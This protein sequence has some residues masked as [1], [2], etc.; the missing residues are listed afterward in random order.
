MSLARIAYVVDGFPKVSQTFIAGEVAELLRRGI[1]VR[2][3]SLRDGESG[4]VHGL[5][6]DADLLD[7]TIYEP[8]D[9]ERVLRDLRPQVIH[10]HFARKATAKAR[11]LAAG[12]GVP[13]TFTA[14]SYDIW[15]RPPPD[16]AERA[17]A[18]AAVITVSQATAAHLA[19]ELDVERD[20]IH[21]INCG[22]DVGRFT[23]RPAAAD[24]PWIVAV[25][26]LHPSKNL[27]LLLEAVASL[28]AQGIQVRVAVVGDGDERDALLRTRN[29][30]GL[31]E[32]VHFTGMA[33]QDEVLDWWH[34]AAIG[35]LSSNVEGMPVA[36]MEAAACGVPVVVTDAGGVAELVDDAVT[37]FV[38]PRG[39]VTAFTDRLVRLVGDPDLRARMAGAA[40]RR[41]EEHCSVVGQVGKLVDVWERALEG[42]GAG[43]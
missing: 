14:H 17:A 18:A 5:A 30:L 36:L 11:S 43:G 9:F 22:I 39:D 8:R 7:R 10:A 24:P 4:A 21:V 3:L 28:V 33:T 37:G 41:A 31:E 40:R 2:I 34:R 38:V 19:N 20:R 42:E 23:P 29:D 13:Y 26:R 15:R 16:L 27:G 35:A 32:I 25:A 12:L 1:D 6:A